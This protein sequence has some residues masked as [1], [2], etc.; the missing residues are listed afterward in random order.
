ME[1]KKYE[2]GS[3]GWFKEQAKKDGF[4]SIPEWNKWRIKTGR[5]DQTAI[6][7]KLDKENIICNNPYKSYEELNKL[8]I[9]RG[10]L[11]L[12]DYV[13]K[14]LRVSNTKINKDLGQYF[15]I[16][17]AEKYVS[18]L[19]EDVIRL[20]INY[21]GYDWICKKGYK[22]QHKASCLIYDDKGWQG[23]AY[24]ILN[25]DIADY[26]ILTGWNNRKDLVPIFILLI[27]SEE[28]V[29]N[30]PFWVRKMFYITNKPKYLLEFEKYN[31]IDKL[32]KL[33]N[34]CNR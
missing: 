30:K 24:N 18:S 23:F 22:I 6:R 26:F 3:L 2:K 7:C 17:V 9:E 1:D 14:E 4:D 29:R 25:N 27:H 13:N 11:N 32:E 12:Q 31:L 34:C 15:G 20:P 28:I 33:K 19:F 21:T 5:L 8:A 16:H 10:Y